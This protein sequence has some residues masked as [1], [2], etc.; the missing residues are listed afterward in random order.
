[1]V[2]P[3][4]DPTS[5]SGTLL[6]AELPGFVYYS[7]YNP[8]DQA[9]DPLLS[10]ELEFFADCTDLVGKSSDE[11][12]VTF[13]NLIQI[14]E[15]VQVLNEF[16]IELEWQF[17]DEGS[18]SDPGEL[19]GGVCHVWG[20]LTVNMESG[21]YEVECGK[22]NICFVEE[23]IDENGV[24]H[25]AIELTNSNLK[26]GTETGGNQSAKPGE[27]VLTTYKITNWSDDPFT[28]T[29][30]ITSDNA[31][32]DVVFESSTGEAGYSYNLSV[33][34]GDDFPM[35]IEPKDATDYD[36]CFPLP[37]PASSISPSAAIEVSVNAGKSQEY[38]V[39]TR[40][41]G[42]CADGS[43]SSMTASLGGQLG[44]TSINTCAGN[45]IIVRIESGDGVQFDSHEGDT[46]PAC[47]DGGEATEGTDCDD[48]EGNGTFGCED[49]VE[50]AMAPGGPVG[51]VMMGPSVDLIAM[52][53][54][55]SSV[56]GG[57]VSEVDTHNITKH[58]S[59]I[60]ENLFLANAPTVG[61]TLTLNSSFHLGANSPEGP[62][63]VTELSIGDK[64]APADSVA[65]S[66]VGLGEATVAAVP[67]ARFQLMLQESIW[68]VDP[69]T[70]IIVPVAIDT[71]SFVVN[72][73]TYTVTIQIT[74][75]EMAP[76]SY[77]LTHDLRA[78]ALAEF[79]V[80][81]SDET[82]N[83]N[84]GLVDCEDDDCAAHPACAEDTG[85]GGEDT[86]EKPTDT[87]E[88]ESCACTST[89]SKS[90]GLLVLFMGA[91]LIW[92]RRRN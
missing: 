90:S 72:G 50:P 18:I 78:Y 85:T 68:A 61:S 48:Y 77:V 28:G 81:C 40:S 30:T 63:T 12:N 54:G 5:A 80:D 36:P 23:I 17:W 82:D 58:Q 27:P 32:N 37:T 71:G 52:F 9:C 45:N 4:H 56:S 87:I 16:P 66:F 60:E 1:M 89:P 42:T 49:W 46:E 39:W 6:L 64:F 88:D 3:V 7:I 20:V 8:N 59:R 35:E 38:K 29:L 57:L 14:D 24:V 22:Q 10:A 33:G 69:N 62:G 74:V 19:E 65:H 34:D 13:E 75:P 47:P 86:G 91:L 79:E 11:L 70:G 76:N 55:T 26:L 25:P 53:D 92:Q 67:N 73:S 44:G 2:L 43:C 21:S 83:D 84:D 51:L 15:L 31:N 41:W